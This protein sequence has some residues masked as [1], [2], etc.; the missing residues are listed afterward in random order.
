M[1]GILAKVAR[2]LLSEEAVMLSPAVVACL[3]VIRSPVA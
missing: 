1:N 3:V 2:F